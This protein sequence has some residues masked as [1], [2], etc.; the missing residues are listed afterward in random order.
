MAPTPKN[1]ILNLLMA[2]NGSALSASD[3][4]TSAGLFGIRENSVRVALVRLNASGLIQSCGRGAYL[5]GPQAASLAD[6][7]ARWRHAEQRVCEWSGA[8]LMVSTASLGRSERGPVRQR[9]R[10]LALLGFKALDEGLHVR[11]DNLIGHARSVRERLHKLGLESQAPVFVATDLDTELD[12]RARRLWRTAERNQGYVRT[13]QTLSQWLE[14]S[15][16]LDAETAARESYLLGND[17][18]RQLVF[19]PL[20]PEPLVDVDARRA[21]HRAVVAFDAAGQ[22]IWQSLLPSLRDAPVALQ[23][24][25]PPHRTPAPRIH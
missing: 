2:A 23:A 12:R 6:D 5:L 3:A 21:C 18:I 25:E 8:W 24:P 9:E 13:Q 14:R 15:H 11:P 4:V 1:L 16:L 17:A 20:L 10:A 7:L 22:R 19:D